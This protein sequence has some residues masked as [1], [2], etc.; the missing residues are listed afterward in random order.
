VLKDAAKKLLAEGPVPHTSEGL[1]AFIGLLNE[2]R[3]RSRVALIVEANRGLPVN[4]LIDVKWL[5]IY[6]VNPMKTRKLNELEG[7]LRQKS[8]QRDCHLLCDYLMGNLKELSRGYI[9]RDSSF[10]QL[11]EWIGME[12]DLIVHCRQLKQ[13]MLSHL[14]VFL[15]DLKE[16]L[17]NFDKKVYVHYLIEFD[18]LNPAPAEQVEAFLRAHHVRD[19]KRIESFVQ[20]HVS[21]RALGRDKGV[22]KVQSEVLREWAQLLWTLRESLEAC[23]GKIQ[24]IFKE[25]PQA[26]IYRSLPGL[27]EILAPRMACLFGSVPNERFACKEQAIAYFG[28]SPVTEQSGKGLHVGKR[29]NCSRYARNTCFLWSMSVNKLPMSHWQRHFLKK[30]QNKGNARPTRYRKLGHKMVGILYRCLMDDAPYDDAF[31]CQNLH[32]K[33]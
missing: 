20:G 24:A 11:Q 27:G 31:Y 7:S 2:H 10:R 14:N 5:D 23:Q 33:A 16:W 15:P 30:L 4:A 21:L 9:E 18:L 1:E 26:K 6:P 12:T 29:R 3:G 13:R 8:D 19:E 32:V 25:L 22:V 28:Q 17:P